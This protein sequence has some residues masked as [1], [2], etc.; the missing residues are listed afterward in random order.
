MD[1]ET[2]ET[3]KARVGLHPTEKGNRRGSESNRR[4]QCFRGSN[5]PR[6]LADRVRG[7][8]NESVAIPSDGPEAED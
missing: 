4:Q 1:D 3:R 7:C 8:G 6:R 2:D 5:W